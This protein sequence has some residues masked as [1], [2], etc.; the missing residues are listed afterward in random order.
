MLKMVFLFS[1]FFN[2]AYAQEDFTAAE[3]A[4][5]KTDALRGWQKRDDQQSL[6]EALSKFEKVHETNPGDLAIVTYLV[7]G[8]Y[9]L[10]DHHQTNEDFK[11]RSFEKAVAYGRR[12]LNTNPEYR[13]HSEDDIEKAISKVTEKEV[14]VLY[15]TAASLGKWSKLNGIMSSLKYKDEILGM[16]KQVEKLQPDY[17]YG[18]VPRYWGSFYAIAPGIAGGDMD[19]SKRKFREAIEKAPEY[20][21]NRVLYAEL[22]LVKRG[23]KKEFKSQLNE[24]LVAP[25]GPKEIEPENLL[26][27]R[28]AEKLLEK[29]DDLF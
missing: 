17:F 22:Y 27:K 2:L 25:K 20:L 8:Y 7:R 6:E 29:K 10:G 9:L 14:P 11:K 26:E 1:I 21:A 16:I 23:D 3:A 24:V 19:K 5:L 18:A 15:W 12:G 28:K 4:L 13:K